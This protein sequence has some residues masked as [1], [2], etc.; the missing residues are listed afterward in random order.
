MVPIVFAVEADR[1][2]SIVDAKPKRSHW[3]KRLANIATDP[4]VSIIVDHYDEDW[5]ALWWARADGSA[6]V[7]EAGPE[8]DQAVALLRSKYP[9]YVSR[10]SPVGAAVVVTVQRWSGWESHRPRLERG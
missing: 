8:H 10:Y 7:V 2:V 9:Q 1:V 6:R 4:R 3:L 5:S